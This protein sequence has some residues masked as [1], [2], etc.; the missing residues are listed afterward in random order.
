MATFTN[1]T[2]SGVTTVTDA[3]TAPANGATVI[4]MSIANT[5]TSVATSCDVTVYDSSEIATQGYVDRYLVRGAPI[6]VGSALAIIGGDQKLVLESGDKL[7]VTATSAVDV[8]T[9]VLEN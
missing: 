6:G 7:K 9:S 8:I 5:S 4:G 3:Y 2:L 1:S